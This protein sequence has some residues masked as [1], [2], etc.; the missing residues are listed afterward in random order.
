MREA[1]IQRKIITWL[2]EQGCYVYKAVGSPY[3]QRGTPDILCILR[4]QAYGLE[5][6]A[7]GGKPTKLQEVELEKIRKAGGVA[8]VV[9]SLD[10]VK[11]LIAEL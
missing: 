3:A 10:E 7:P 11:E 9:T 4:G 5:V 6:K 1:P 2:R 8:A